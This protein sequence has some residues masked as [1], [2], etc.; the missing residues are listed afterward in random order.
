MSS[1]L[2]RESGTLELFQTEKM[3]VKKH[4]DYWLTKL[5][6]K[7]EKDFWNFTNHILKKNKVRDTGPIQEVNS[8]AINTD[9][10][11]KANILTHSF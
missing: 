3:P 5:R 9:D 4:A 2:P 6:T 11:K 8:A 1:S 10:E 7:S